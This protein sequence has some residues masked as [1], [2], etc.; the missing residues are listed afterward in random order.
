MATFFVVLDASPSQAV[1]NIAADIDGR[2][3]H[4]YGRRALIIDAGADAVWELGARPAVS[5]VFPMIVPAE[6][7]A[8][9]DEAGQLGAAAWNARQSPPRRG[10]KE[11]TGEGFSW[12][13][14]GFEAEG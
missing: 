8:Q 5:G 12:G 11:R 14:P 1:S 9:L 6:V 10:T 13:H 3:T 4:R 2:V 7:V